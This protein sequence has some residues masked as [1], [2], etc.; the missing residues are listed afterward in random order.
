[1]GAEK[2]EKKDESKGKKTG[3]GKVSEKA[4]VNRVI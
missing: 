2:G 1:M 3:K 4:P